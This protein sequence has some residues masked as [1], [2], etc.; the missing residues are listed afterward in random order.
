LYNQYLNTASEASP[1]QY[2][3][4]AQGAASRPYGYQDIQPAQ[5]NPYSQYEQNTS[6]G[7][8]NASGFSAQSQQIP[9]NT[10]ALSELTRSLSGKLQGIKFDMNTVIMLAIVWFLLSDNGEV[11]WNQFLTIGVLFI[12]GL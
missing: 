3:Y 5:G 6:E 9:H 12:L 2:N 11:D 4:N 10:A 8:E 7:N 1:Y